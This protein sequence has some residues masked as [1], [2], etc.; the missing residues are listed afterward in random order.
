MIRAKRR[1][2]SAW[3]AADHQLG[4][5]LNEAQNITVVALYPWH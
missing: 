2:A 3:P 1:S 5:Q 4:V